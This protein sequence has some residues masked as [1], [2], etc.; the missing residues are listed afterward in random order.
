ME[1]PRQPLGFVGSISLV[2]EKGGMSWGSSV[3]IVFDYRVDDWGLSQAEAK[4][5]SSN[6]CVQTSS[7][8]HPT[9]Y[10]MS[11]G[12]FFPHQ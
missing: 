3:S 11:T 9:S 5:F 1:I 2:Y 12:G 10:P 4:D 7:E 8:A 6:L